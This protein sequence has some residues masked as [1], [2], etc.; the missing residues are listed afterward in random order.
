M[1]LQNYIS[2]IAPSVQ[3]T[4]GAASAVITIPNDASGQKARAV[5]ICSKAGVYILPQTH[6]FGFGH[7]QFSA[8]VLPSN[9]D[10]VT[11]GGTVITWKTSG[12]VGNEIN[13]RANNR[14]NAEALAD[15]CNASADANLLTARYFYSRTDGQDLRVIVQSRTVNLNTFT[16]VEASAATT[17]SAGT[18]TGGSVTAATAANSIYIVAG[19][20]LKL[21][22]AAITG[23]AYIQETAA[24]TINI[25]PIECQ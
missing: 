3:V 5:H 6:P 11:L 7:V 19:E 25:S 20:S 17:V 24:T 12:A 2:N 13:I 14:L 8:T 15:F 22:V 18:V 23:L 21:N 10:T 4:S 1:K 9:N 16:L